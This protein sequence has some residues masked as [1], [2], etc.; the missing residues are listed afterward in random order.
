MPK[1]QPLGIMAS[2]SN[3]TFKKDGKD[4]FSASVTSGGCFGPDDDIKVINRGYEEM[5]RQGKAASVDFNTVALKGQF[6][7][8]ERSYEVAVKNNAIDAKS[9]KRV[10]P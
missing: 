8:S 6:G 7:G 3:V 10:Q 1:H 5:K 4:V 2:F 9:L